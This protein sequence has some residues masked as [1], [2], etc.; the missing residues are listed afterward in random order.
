[1][2]TLMNRNDFP[3]R[4]LSLSFAFLQ[5][6]SVYSHVTWGDDGGFQFRPRSDSNAMSDLDALRLELSKASDANGPINPLGAYLQRAASQSKASQSKSAPS[7]VEIGPD[8]EAERKPT[9]DR[10][11]STANAPKPKQRRNI[12]MLAGPRYTSVQTSRAPA[13][14]ADGFRPSRYVTDLEANVRPTLDYPVTLASTQDAAAGQTTTANYQDLP[15]GATNNQPSTNV[16]PPAPLGVNPSNLGTI[17]SGGAVPGSFPPSSFPPGSFPPSNFPPGS[18]PPGSFPPGSLVPSNGPPMTQPPNSSMGSPPAYS[19]PLPNSNGVNPT[20]I[21]PPLSPPP[22]FS[23]GSVSGNPASIG[24]GFAIPFGNPGLGN[25]S[26]VSPSDNVMPNYPRSR[27]APYV[28][29]AP[30]VSS[31]PCQ[32]DANYMVS[33]TVYRQSLDPCGPTRNAPSGYAGSPFAYTPPTAMPN[34]SMGNGGGYKPLI[35]FGQSLNGAYFGR[36]IIGQ[37]VAYIN[38]QPVRNLIR[39]VFP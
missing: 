19:A 18:F 39:Y 3:I 35:G 24:P 1:M 9:L 13:M 29:G 28:N 38:G 26:M 37:P 22:Q 7:G 36:G 4:S 6:L 2:N 32:F 30:F 23:P 16:M 8:L 27:G 11:P 10:D 31:A 33:P 5:F 15:F 17:G 20:Y 14:L 21:P 34:Y 25:G 12:V